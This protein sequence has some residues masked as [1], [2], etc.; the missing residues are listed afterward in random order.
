MLNFKKSTYIKNFKLLRERKKSRRL[1]WEFSID[2]NIF[3][4]KT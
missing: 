4:K 3:V 1:Q 2:I